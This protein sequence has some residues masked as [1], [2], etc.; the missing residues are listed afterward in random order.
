MQLPNKSLCFSTLLVALLIKPTFVWCSQPQEEPDTTIAFRNINVIDV[1]GGVVVPE[2]TVVVTGRQISF[3]GQIVP[4]TLLKRSRIIDATGLYVSPGF[5]DMHV[6]LAPYGSEKLMGPAMVANGVLYARDM[7]GD[8][9]GGGCSHRRTVDEMRELQTAIDTG[10]V[11]APRIVSAASY[12]VEGPKVSYDDPRWPREPSFLAP[13]NAREGRLLAEHMAD[14][15]VDFIKSYDSLPREAYF[16]LAEEAGR[17]NLKVAGHVPKA[18]RLIEAIEAG[19]HT[20]EHAK[21]LPLACSRTE[22]TFREAYDKW[23]RATDDAAPRGRSHASVSDPEPRLADYYRSILSTPDGRKC[24]RLLEAWAQSETYYVPTHLTRLAEASVHTRPYRYDARSE[25]IVPAVIRDSWEREART[26]EARFEA[27]PLL[28]KAYKDFHLRGM[29]L[30]GRAHRAGVRIL[31]GTDLGDTLIYPG[32]SYHDEL[33]L[34][35]EAG[36]STAEVLRSATLTASMFE[37]MD[38]TEGTIAASKSA[39]LIL[40]KDNPLKDIV[41]TKAIEAVYYQ[42]RYYDRASLDELLANVRADALSVAP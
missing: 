24:E 27:D 36:M 17:V 12:P 40:Y 5:W 35:V 41:N 9:A 22:E 34:M 6:H 26:Y 32:F 30:T 42:G 2:Q 20:I 38:A 19:Q 37:G 25:Y 21:M 4:P 33:A 29:E 14:R 3:V 39:N 8:C 1:E 18:V 10:R 13:A 15:G 7:N 23:T 11:L 31:A 28:E 16:G